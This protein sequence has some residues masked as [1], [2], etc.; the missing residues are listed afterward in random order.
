[1]LLGIIVATKGIQ[2]LNLSLTMK[3]FVVRSTWLTLYF[4]VLVK[5]R[6]SLSPGSEHYMVLTVPASMR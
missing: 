2:G 6:L 1:M 4:L 5:Y 3:I